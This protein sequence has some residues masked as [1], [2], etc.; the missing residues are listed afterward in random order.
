MPAPR[1]ARRPWLAGTASLAALAATGG[2]LRAE[3]GMG[4][5]AARH[6]LGR[7]ALGATPGEIERVARLD[8]ATAVAGL[9]A[10]RRQVALTAVPDWAESTAAGEPEDET[11]RD[12]LRAWWVAEMLATDRPL[13][14]RLVLF[15]HGHFTSSFHKVR[16]APA[17]W[18]Q[19][20]LFRRHALGNYATLLRAV[21]RDPAM[22]TYL[23]GRES[24]A[25]A[26]NENFA[27][28]LLELFTLGEGHYREADVRAAARAFTGWTVD[29]RSGRFV[30]RP[31]R[32]DDGEKAFLGHSGRLDGDA[33]L[34][35]LLQHP[36]TAE[37]VVEK[38]WREF[39]SPQPDGAAVRRLATAFRVDYEIAPLLAAL[40]LSPEFDEPAHR[41]VLIKGPIELVAGTVRLL[42]LPVPQAGGL[43]RM[44]QELGQIPFDPPDVRG[45]PGGTTWINGYTLTRR[46]DVVRRIVEASTVAPVE[47]ADMQMVAAER[48]PVEGR[49]LRDAA[50]A[51][52]LGRG[53]EGIQGTTWLKTVLPCPPVEAID[54][55][56]PAGVVVA[57]ALLDPAYQ[58][59]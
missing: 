10:D 33:V 36:R 52:R 12:A 58:L 46:Q 2:A 39:V 17:L 25:E 13:V 4:F 21:A 56:A 6:L 30:I 59:K 19:N 37:T 40:L 43:V 9:L 18:R 54:A 3:A 31:E 57:G 28:E 35:R 49:S 55:A 14:E 7:T 22:L 53:L 45:W 42:G 23:D 16:D 20:A 15:W 24:V 5:D 27:R 8:R 47:G 50:A 29:P 11:Q 38:L 44:M 32:H 26:P 48:R 1:L 41:G 34:A 51:A